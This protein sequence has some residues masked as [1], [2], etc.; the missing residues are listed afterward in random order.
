MG[1][2]WNINKKM[3]FEI[4]W[5]ELE[6]I[7]QIKYEYIYIFIYLLNIYSHKNMRN[8]SLIRILGKIEIWWIYKI[9]KKEKRIIEELWFF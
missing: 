9:N 3:I 5:Y 6:I 7:F 2:K 1:M 8:Y 4:W